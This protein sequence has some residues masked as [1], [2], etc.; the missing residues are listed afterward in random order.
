MSSKKL[1]YNRLR[2]LLDDQE[3]EEFIDNVLVDADHIFEHD[4][5]EIEVQIYLE[6]KEYD[7]LILFCRRN[8]YQADENLE[9][10]GK[11]MPLNDQKEA[12]E[13]I[14]NRTKHCIAGCK[15]SKGLCLS[16]Q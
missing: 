13:Y 16:C 9:K 5:D 10:Y 4:F 7:K 15:R 8:T 2:E 11:Y 3:W 14:A 1:Y 12:A 6:R